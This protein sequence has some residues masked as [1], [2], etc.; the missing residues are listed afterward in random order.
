V[1]ERGLHVHPQQHAEPDQVD[2]QLLGRRRQQRHDDE[3]QLEEIEEEGQQED[4]N[5]H[6]DQEADLTAGQAAQQMLDPQV[7]LDTVEGEREDPRTDQDHH[8]EGGQPRSA[9]HRLLELRHVDAAAHHRQHQRTKAPIAP[10]SVGVAIPRK[11]VPS[12]RKI[13]SSGGSRL[14]I[15]RSA[16]LPPRSVR[17]SRA[18]PAP[19]RA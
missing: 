17:A 19:A 5:V 18:G 16:S 11:I 7:A 1:H 14:V 9:L 12:T 8:H 4:Q 3:G 2:A 6:H 15:T 13:S 10:P